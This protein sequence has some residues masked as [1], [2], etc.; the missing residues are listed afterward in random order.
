ML[1]HF[2]EFT[3][4]KILQSLQGIMFQ[5]LHLR[6]RTVYSISLIHG[7]SILL[8]YGKQLL[9][10]LAC[11]SPV[12]LPAVQ[13]AS[14]SHAYLVR[15]SPVVRDGGMGMGTHRSTDTSSKGRTFQGCED[16]SVGVVFILNF[17]GPIQ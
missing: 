16:S 1:F 5:R 17:P 4:A 10:A 9:D 6:I 8:T 15:P 3:R 7:L 13:P 2:Q 12:R 14:P 11:P